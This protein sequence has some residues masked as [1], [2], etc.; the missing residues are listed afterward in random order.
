M[1]FVLQTGIAGWN[2]GSPAYANAAL[3]RLDKALKD[4]QASE[5]ADIENVEIKGLIPEFD[6]DATQKCWQVGNSGT[7]AKLPRDDA[8][9][10]T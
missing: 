9:M 10:Q 3:R 1:Y 4:L 6:W 2:M 8:V 5:R 7:F